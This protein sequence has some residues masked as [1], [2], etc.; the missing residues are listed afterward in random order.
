MDAQRLGLWGEELAARYLS[1]R[2]LR[3]IDRQYRQKW[4]ELDLICKDRDTWVF[5]EV[6][7]RSQAY[8]PKAIEAVNYRKQQRLSRAAMS[9]ILWK[10]LS[11][12]PMR[13]DVV[14]I[15]GSRVEWFQDAFEISPRYTC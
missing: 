6:K 2:G 7:T 8:Q 11:G 12:Q 3:V 5:V 1:A 4:G 9:Y 15:E 14:V 10:R 13:F